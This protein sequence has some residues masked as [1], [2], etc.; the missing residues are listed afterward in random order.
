MKTPQT[1]NSLK[2]RLQGRCF[3]VNFAKFLRSL[4]FRE[5]LCTT[6]SGFFH[7]FYSFCASQWTN[8]NHVFLYW[9]CF[10]TSSE[11]DEHHEFCNWKTILYETNEGTLKHLLKLTESVQSLCSSLFLNGVTRQRLNTSLKRDLWV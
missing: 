9:T 10:I 4:F 8:K 6:A 1:C 5:H 2:K 3:S 7:S 11:R